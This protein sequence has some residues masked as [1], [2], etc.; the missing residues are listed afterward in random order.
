MSSELCCGCT[1]CASVCPK[2]CISFCIDEEGFKIPKVDE[3]KCIDCGLCK[4]TCPALNSDFE[5]VLDFEQKTY[6][7]QYLDDKVRKNR[8]LV[9]YF[10]HLLISSLRVLMGMYVVVFWMKI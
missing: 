1:A 3:E 5:S 4:K 7:F 9:L 2:K 10:Q 6:A 8:L